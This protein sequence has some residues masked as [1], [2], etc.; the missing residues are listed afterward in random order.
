M[1]KQ[2]NSQPW[3]KIIC[4]SC[5]LFLRRP[6]PKWKTTSP[7]IEDNLT[8]NGR[9]PHPKLYTNSPKMEDYLTQNGRRP[10]P[11]WKKSSPKMEDIIPKIEDHLTPNW[12]KPQPKW[13][14]TK[15]EEGRIKLWW[16]S[17]IRV[18][19]IFALQDFYSLNYLKVF[20]LKIILT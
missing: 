16:F 6:H 5:I 13:T 20:C 7:K 4:N 10:H 17:R 15:N 19:H 1:D 11:K 18:L 3:T 9:R 2:V 12:R 14:K 8:Q